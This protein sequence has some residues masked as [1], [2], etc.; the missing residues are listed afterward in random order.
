MLHRLGYIIGYTDISNYR[1]EI[2]LITTK[3]TT[4]NT[5]HGTGQLMRREPN[6][7]CGW[8]E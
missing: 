7:S 4:Y 2:A 6:L 1:P 5:A 3:S 8:T